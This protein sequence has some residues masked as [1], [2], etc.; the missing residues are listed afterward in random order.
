M[1]HPFLQS[2]QRGRPGLRAIK[3]AT[4]LA[5][6]AFSWLALVSEAR[7]DADANGGAGANTGA[8]ATTKTAPEF[9]IGADELRLDGRITGVDAAQKRVVMEAASFTLPNGKTKELLPVKSKNVLVT[10]ATALHVRGDA[11][12]KVALADLPIGA[13]L[14]V[15]GRDEGGRGLVAR[16][17]VVW[18][19]LEKGEFRLNSQ[20]PA[21]AAQPTPPALAGLSLNEARRHLLDYINRDRESQGL[22]PLA[23]DESAMKATQR[24]AEDMA[25]GNYLSSYD[26]E[27]KLPG[28]RYTEAG[29][30][31][32]LSY[33]GAWQ[34]TF[35]AR[36]AA[37]DLLQKVAEPRFEEAELSFL[38]KSYDGAREFTIA[39]TT[40]HI[41]IG[42][43]KATDGN[44]T[45][46]YNALNLVNRLLAQ[47][48]AIPQTAKVGD[49]IK[50]SGRLG[51]GT[52]MDTI[53]VGRA[54]LP[55]PANRGQLKGV[56]NWKR[57]EDHLALRARQGDVQVGADGTFEAQVPLSRDE[58]PGLYYVSI[59]VR[60][61]KPGGGE[62]QLLASTRTV[63]VE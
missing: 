33:T 53:S 23:L 56:M 6:A 15:V 47:V 60:V 31:G 63:V 10:A 16:Q 8:A 28:Q 25:E 5:L 36:K 43:S 41:G 42:L 49:V 57:P 21:A 39:P 34:R 35:A 22:L 9:S 17:A 61:P 38:R 62:T 44:V 46:T 20:K 14:I 50:V 45:T 24:H 18:N 26:R 48:D 51:Q 59:W 12:R 27:G 11:A 13:S 37:G 54:L 32:G 29:G 1:R 3:T 55:A 52:T 7:A 58:Q 30:I 19:A 2:L 40:T 4:V